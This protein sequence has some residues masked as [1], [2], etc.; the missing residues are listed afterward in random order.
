M[1]P[2]GPLALW[3]N[4]TDILVALLDVPSIQLGFGL[5][6]K[7]INLIC[8]LK[9]QMNLL[10]IWTYRYHLYSSRDIMMLK[11]DGQVGFFII[12]LFVFFLNWNKLSVATTSNYWISNI[13]LS[14]VNDKSNCLVSGVST[15]LHSLNQ[16]QSTT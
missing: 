3:Y 15:V 11:W 5:D 14:Y 9:G 4:G 7:L 2:R 13:C 1:I 16:S 8:N 6:W 12:S 10:S